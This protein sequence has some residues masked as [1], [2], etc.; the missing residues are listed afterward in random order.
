MA[1]KIVAANWKMN[2]DEYSS[3]SLAYEFLKLVN[4]QNN[5][6]TLKILC[7]PFPFLATINLM[8]QGAESVYVG[9]QNCSSFNKGAFTGEVSANMLQSLK[10]PYVIIGHSERRELFF[11][12]S[13]DL[14]KKVELALENNIS[15]IFCCGEPLGIREKNNHI[16]YV[17]N[18]LEETVF[19]LTAGDFSKL[20]L[21]Y[22]PIWAIGT[23]ETA[24]SKIITEAH[25]MIRKILND[26]GFDGQKI[27]ILYGGSVN[28]NNAK[29]L[30]ALTDVDGFLIGGASL[31]AEHFL[32][33]YN[34][35]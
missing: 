25:Q 6:N 26:I 14:I 31:D 34:F 32:D 27:S 5:P 23:G 15:P 4:N 35:F 30:I 8:C 29:E 3:K 13:E 21:A 7:V 9:A 12:K 16:D 2:N 19:N 11:E 24:T 10:I 1:K 33:I 17:I 20:I 22:E 18:Q 28:I